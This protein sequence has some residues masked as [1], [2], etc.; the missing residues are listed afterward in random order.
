MAEKFKSLRGQLLLDSGQLTGSFFHRTVVLICQHNDEG[1]FGLVI[2]RP[3][4]N[5]VGDAL[6]AEVPESLKDQTLYLGGPVQ[7]TALSYLHNDS[8]IPDA[9]VISNLEL[10]HS[11][12]SL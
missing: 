10:G 11:L 7:P 2:N 6:T 9:N 4:E 3:T 12:E 1:A 8:F 5:K